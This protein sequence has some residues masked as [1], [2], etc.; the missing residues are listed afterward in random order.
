MTVMTSWLGTFGARSI[1]WWNVYLKL[2]IFAKVA[3][4]AQRYST[5]VYRSLVLTQKD[6]WIQ[7]KIFS[8]ICS[9]WGCEISLK[10]FLSRKR[11]RKMES[12]DLS[13]KD[14]LMICDDGFVRNLVFKFDTSPNFSASSDLIGRYE[15]F[16]L[17]LLLWLSWLSGRFQD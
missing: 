16:S 10:V 13:D 1:P 9:S 15:G 7:T 8:L 3:S 4:S 14:S 2:Y 6:G 12:D 17:G 11:G 5:N